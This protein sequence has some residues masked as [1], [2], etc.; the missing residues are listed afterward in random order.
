MRLGSDQREERRVLLHRQRELDAGAL[1]WIGCCDH[2]NGNAREY[3]WW[4]EQKL[5]D[6]FYSPGTFVPMFA[7]ERSVVYPEG[8][9]NVIFAQRGIRTLPRAP[10]SAV[11]NPVHAPD[12]QMLYAYLRYFDG[13]VASHT[14]ATNMGTDWREPGAGK[15]LPV[16][17]PGQLRS[18]FHAHQLL[19]YLREGSDARQCAGRDQEAPCVRRDR[20]HPGRRALG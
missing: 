19:Q 15:G 11:D 16:G 3:T 14:S 9:R 10:I 18:R 17:L 4:I 8:H 6:I 2:D 5:T 1:D 12:T 7:Y 20:Q 13:I